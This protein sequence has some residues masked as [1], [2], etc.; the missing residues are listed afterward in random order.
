MGVRGMLGKAMCKVDRDLAL[1][2][3]LSGG[4][5]PPHGFDPDGDQRLQLLLEGFTVRA[6]RV[7]VKRHHGPRCV[8]SKDC[9]LS[10]GPDPRQYALRQ[11]VLHG[12]GVAKEPVLS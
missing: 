1:Q 12:E 11:F 9:A 4:P 8:S 7:L 2:A 5:H 10:V 6:C 3:W